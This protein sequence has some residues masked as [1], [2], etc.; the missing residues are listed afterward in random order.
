[1]T[2][3]KKMQI[4]TGAL[5]T[6]AMACALS[7]FFSMLN[8]GFSAELPLVWLKSF[9]MGWPVGFVVSALVGRPIQHLASR[10]AGYSLN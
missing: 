6:T 7:G 9:V 10:L 2:T 1:M 5:M 3:Q 8:V 4:I